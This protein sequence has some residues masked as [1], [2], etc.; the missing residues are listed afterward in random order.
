[1]RIGHLV[2]FEDEISMTKPKATT[3]DKAETKE[4]AD[5]FEFRGRVVP[6]INGNPQFADSKMMLV[7]CEMRGQ[8]NRKGWFSYNKKDGKEAKEAKEQQLYIVCPSSLAKK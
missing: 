4:M 8:R 2:Q 6:I 3:K 1:M 5:L 7:P